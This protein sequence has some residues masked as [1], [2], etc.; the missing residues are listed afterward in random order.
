MADY[1]WR[2]SNPG[3]NL[4]QVDSSYKNLALRAKYTV[5]FPAGSMPFRRAEL[6]IPMS[7]NG[8]IAWRCDQPA[9]YVY[10]SGNTCVF[11]SPG[12]FPPGTLTVY[13]FDEPQYSPLYGNYGVRSK[14]AAW[15]VTFD[16]RYKYMKL[17]DLYQGSIIG[18]P[19]NETFSRT[20]AR[21]PAIVQGNLAYVHAWLQIGVSPPFQYIETMTMQYVSTP[22]AGTVTWHLVQHAQPMTLFPPPG[23]IDT[24]QMTRS[25]TIMD[26]AGL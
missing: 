15:G 19:V 18:A 22:G 3:T 4:I 1:G 12:G 13:V 7:P 2:V 9:A 6:S 25:H 8:V 20:Y 14:D 5:A 10:R 11:W 24:Q 17:Q 16:S 26:V 21:L 23:F